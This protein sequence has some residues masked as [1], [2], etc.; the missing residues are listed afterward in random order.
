[1]IVRI[2]G[3]G[4]LAVPDNVLGELNVLDDQLVTT[5]DAE[6]ETAFRAALGALLSRVRAY[7]SPLPDDALTPSE[8]VLPAADAD[9]TEVRGM[10]RGESLRGEGLRGEGL[11]G[12]G[13]VPDSGLR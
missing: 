3:E 9:L 6:D 7:G 2:L 4:Q 8:L 10:L 5:M 1:M 11:R 13:L 12:E